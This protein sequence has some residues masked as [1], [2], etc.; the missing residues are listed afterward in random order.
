[1]AQDN[2]GNYITAP[3]DNNAPEVRYFDFC[4]IMG[5]GPAEEIAFREGQAQLLTDRI[6]ACEVSH[7]EEIRELSQGVNGLRLSCQRLEE[8][9]RQCQHELAEHLAGEV[10][11]LT[12]SQKGLFWGHAKDLRQKIKQF[13]QNVRVTRNEILQQEGAIRHLADQHRGELIGLEEHLKETTDRIYEIRFPRVIE[14]FDY[15]W[16]D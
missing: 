9:I 3:A 2:N 14:E 10:V 11:G 7:P 6:R 16:N 15:D 12:S 8:E 4:P 13:Q 1:M 5:L